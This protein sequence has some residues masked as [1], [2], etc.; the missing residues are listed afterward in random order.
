MS[1]NILLIRFENKHL[2]FFAGFRVFYVKKGRKAHAKRSFQTTVKAVKFNY[3]QCQLMYSDA[4][5][6]VGFEFFNQTLS[7]FGI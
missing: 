2:R 6:D 3:F 5:F 7:E 4:E 1:S